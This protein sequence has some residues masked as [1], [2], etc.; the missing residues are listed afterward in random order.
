[1]NPPITPPMWKTGRNGTLHML[2]GSTASLWLCITLFTPLY[3][4]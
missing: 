3:F 1:M 4:L 2:Y